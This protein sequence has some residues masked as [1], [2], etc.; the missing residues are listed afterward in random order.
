M[1]DELFGFGGVQD[2]RASASSSFHDV[3]KSL[4]DAG[5][6]TGDLL[7]EA[8]RLKE[9]FSDVF[10]LGAIKEWNAEFDAF[11]KK[12]NDAIKQQE[13]QKKQD[14][15]F[16]AAFNKELEKEAAENKKASERNAAFQTSKS[17]SQSNLNVEIERL[18]EIGV[19]SG[20]VKENY[21]MLNGLLSEVKTPESLTSWSQMLKEISAKTKEVIQENNRLKNSIQSNA[22]VKA[23]EVES[24]KLKNIDNWLSSSQISGASTAGISAIRSEIVSLQNEYK[25][26]VGGLR[27]EGIDSATYDNLLAKLKSLDEQY[28]KLKGTAEK[29]GTSINAQNWQ[30]KQAQKIDKLKSNFEKIQN[31]W[32]KAMEVPELRSQIDDFAIS[33]KILMPQMLIC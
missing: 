12:A 1:Y 28:N 11:S 25:S 7:N 5:L 20:E 26:V 32:S 15:K 4:Q 9:S 30:E 23:N 22:G 14:D 10:D 31:D 33:L 18:K 3:T 19:Y 6:L 13:Q 17:V 21:E 24:G 29:F 8:S 2:K 27:A 16:N